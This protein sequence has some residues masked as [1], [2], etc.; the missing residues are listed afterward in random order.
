MIQA[1]TAIHGGNLIFI[2][3]R[4]I[5]IP[6]IWRFIHYAV[7]NKWRF[8]AGRVPCPALFGCSLADTPGSQAV[9]CS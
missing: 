7:I 5:S 4:D 1:K 9:M 6:S 2:I 3:I 8:P